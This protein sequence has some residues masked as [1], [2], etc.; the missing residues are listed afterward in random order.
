MELQSKYELSKNLLT[1]INK[2]TAV[3]E[4][5]IQQITKLQHALTEELSS[6][7]LHKLLFPFSLSHISRYSPLPLSLFHSLSLS[8]IPPSLFTHYSF[9]KPNEYLFFFCT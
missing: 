7:L 3:K 6:G 2:L 8:I 5:M 1:D 4:Q 9:I